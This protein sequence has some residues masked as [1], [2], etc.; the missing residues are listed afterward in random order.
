MRA[1]DDQFIGTVAVDL[2]ERQLLPKSVALAFIG[3]EVDP[4]LVDK[5]VIE[6]FKFLLDRFRSTLSTRDLV[7]YCKLC[8]RAIRV[9]LT[10]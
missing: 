5:C 2:D 4:L 7:L 3:T 9:A 10:P 8:G 1:H 6:A